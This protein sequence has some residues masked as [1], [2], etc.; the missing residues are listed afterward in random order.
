MSVG[1]ANDNRRAVR[2]FK[3]VLIDKGYDLTYR[4]NHKGHNWDNWKPLLPDVLHTFF[5]LDAE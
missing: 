2:R 1:S 5:G 4:Q 3:N